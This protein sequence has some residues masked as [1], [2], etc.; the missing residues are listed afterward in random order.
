MASEYGGYFELTGIF[1]LLLVVNI[2]HNRF[3]FGCGSPSSY[4]CKKKEKKCLEA[5]MAYP[6]HWTRLVLVWQ[7]KCQCCFLFMTAA[8]YCCLL[9]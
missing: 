1:W 7:E 2:F 3:P 9:T 4:L 5:I 8:H 6:G